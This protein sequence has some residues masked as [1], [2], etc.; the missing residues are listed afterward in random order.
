[1]NRIKQF[2]AVA[3]LGCM[4][5]TMTMAQDASENEGFSCRATS[6][7]DYAQSVMVEEAFRLQEE[8]APQ[9]GSRSTEFRFSFMLLNN[10]ARKY[11]ALCPQESEN[12]PEKICD[13]ALSFKQDVVD[14]YNAAVTGREDVSS[15]LKRK[16]ASAIKSVIDTSLRIGMNGCN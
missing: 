16:T 8:L 13:D 12:K 7:R 15:E 2:T 5:S 14:Q 11:A 1:M 3:A 6:E 9:V 4:T 10:T